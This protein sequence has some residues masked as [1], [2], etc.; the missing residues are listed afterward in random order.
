MKLFGLFV[1]AVLAVV[2]SCASK[3]APDPVYLGEVPP[4]AVYAPSDDIGPE[5]TPTPQLVK[6]T[7]GVPKK[8]VKKKKSVKKV[9]KKS[10]KKKHLN[11]DGE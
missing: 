8:E 1:V 7:F 10:K 11:P 4:P 3:E 5:P 2:A 6:K 9:S